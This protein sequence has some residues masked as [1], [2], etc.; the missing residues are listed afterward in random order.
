MM[1]VP[2]ATD[3]T[4]RAGA[5]EVLFEQQYY[6]E[7]ARRTYDLAPDGQRFLM[8]TPNASDSDADSSAPQIVLVQNWLDELRAR[9]PVN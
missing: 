4:L 5:P 3:P 7:R 9:V 6:F 8:I 1:A 2:I